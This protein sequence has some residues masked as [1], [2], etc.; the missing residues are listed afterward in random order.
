MFDTNYWGMVN[1]SLAAVPILEKRGG[2]LINIGSVLSEMSMPLQGHYS[3]SKHAVMGFTNALRMELEKRDAGIDV[4]LVKPSAINTTYAQHARNHM[5]EEATLPPPVYA[6]EV[7][8]RAILRL[9]THPQRDVTIGG[10]GK[11][12][13]TMA[14]LAPRLMDKIVEATQ[15]SLQ[16]KD[17]PANG[18]S[19]G[20]LTQSVDASPEMDAKRHGDVETPV[21]SSSLYT[22]TAQHPQA[23]A[24]AA[25][26]AIAGGAA[27]LLLRKD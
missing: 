23:T 18:R 3:A 27:W 5:D 26:A 16:K 4:C 8:A 10:G 2:T 12:M 22:W 6:P 7:V 21:L 17:T 1:G 11:T 20:A 14:N 19:H 9:A 15:F 24:A 13:T 25:A